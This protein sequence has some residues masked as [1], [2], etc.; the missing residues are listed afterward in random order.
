MKS[1]EI[2]A[3]RAQDIV[4]MINSLSP[5]ETAKV[6]P[7]EEMKAIRFSVKLAEEILEA[8]KAYGDAFAD[9]NS[10]AEEVRKPFMDKLEAAKKADMP[11]DERTP[12]LEKLLSEANAAINE[13][14]DS[15]AKEIGMEGLANATITVSIASD[16]RWAFLKS[17]F[18]KVAFEKFN[19]AKAL[20]E[21]I[22]AIEAA[23]EA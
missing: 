2:K 11:E 23:K 16:E 8:N 18:A 4:N 14:A 13:V 5:A 12:F 3:V 17:L 21:T 10:K 7:G 6:L 15:R 22:D 20:V 1:F 9:V 19:N